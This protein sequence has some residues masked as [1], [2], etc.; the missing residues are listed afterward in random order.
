MVSYDLDKNAIKNMPKLKGHQIIGELRHFVAASPMSSDRLKGHQIIGELRHKKR[1]L[2]VQVLLKG[3][4]IIGE[5]RPLGIS[6]NF[7]DAH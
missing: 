2:N 3:H 1:K 7:N 6:K 4:Q 5:L